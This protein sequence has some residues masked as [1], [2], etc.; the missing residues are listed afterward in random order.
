MRGK[1]VKAIPEPTLRP[2]PQAPRPTHAAHPPTP[3]PTR[4]PTNL[5]SSDQEALSHERHRDKRL[6]ER[7]EGQQPAQ[8]AQDGGVGGEAP[9]SDPPQAE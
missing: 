1:S 4:P 9:R 2:T 8:L 6:L 3:T 7:E 5:S